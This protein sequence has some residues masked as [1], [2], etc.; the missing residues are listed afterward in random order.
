MSAR[1]GR[2]ARFSWTAPAWF[3]ALGA[4]LPIAVVVASIAG[5]SEGVFAHIAETRLAVYARN[6]VLLTL[7]V[8]MT[9]LVLGVSTAWLVTMFR[10]PGRWLLSIVLLLPMAV[11][12]YIAAYSVT[13]LLQPAGPLRAIAVG[14]DGVRWWWPRVRSLPGAT[15]ILALC[16]Y[17][18][19]YLAARAAFIALP[20]SLLDAAKTLGFGSIGTFTR[21]RRPA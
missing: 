2:L 5:D 14:E 20:A 17:P 19:V 18:Y 21:G 8:A 15:L 13:D 12:A 7:G 6:T 3:I 4:L 16:L 11:P 10:F 9:T 1:L